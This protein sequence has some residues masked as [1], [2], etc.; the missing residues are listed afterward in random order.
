MKRHVR[1][2]QFYR[3]QKGRPYR[4]GNAGTMLFRKR[5][6]AVAFRGTFESW[7]TLRPSIILLVAA[8]GC[9]DVAAQA[10][11]QFLVNP[12]ATKPARVP[13]TIADDA[14]STGPK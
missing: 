1:C 12:A 5:F 6:V 8:L 3:L 2:R 4:M 13:D 14:L 11:K 10:P 9:V 7:M